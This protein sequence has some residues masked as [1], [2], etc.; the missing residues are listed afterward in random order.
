MAW[1][2]VP[3]LE[4]SRSDFPC[5]SEKA[6]EPCVSSN[7]IL[8]PH[9]LSWAGWRTRPWI[10]RLSGTISRPSMANRGAAS[11]I[12]SLADTHASRSPS[13]VSD[14]ERRIDAI[15][16][17]MYFGSSEKSGRRSVS[18]RTCQ[19]ISDWA[20]PK[21]EPT[22]D[23][24]VMRLRRD[25]LRRQKLAQ[26]TRENVFS[27]WPTVRACSGNRSSGANRTDFYRAWPT[28]DCSDRRGPA[29]AQKGLKNVIE[30]WPTPTAT[31]REND[32]RAIPSRATLERY[33]RGQIRR[34]RKTRAPTLLKAVAQWPTPRT[35]D[36]EGGQVAGTTWNKKGFRS[37]RNKSGQIRGAKL[38]DAVEV[39]WPTPRADQGASRKPGTG[40]RCLPEE[41]NVT[42]KSLLGRQALR[43][44][45]GGRKSSLNT[46][47]SPPLWRTPHSAQEIG[48]KPEELTGKGLGH[49]MYRKD[50]TNH[51][52]DTSL[53]A[54][55]VMGDSAKRLNP[56]F[57]EWLMGFPLAWT[58][59]GVSG[60]QLSHYRRHMRSLLYGLISR[61]GGLL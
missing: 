58:G 28:P 2:F 5:Y 12:S 6:I 33:A 60:M 50:G 42:T 17:R 44:R 25:C 23:H 40:G 51:T 38:R 45:M 48:V 24:L 32:T 56:L 61:D 19:D 11:W 46:R 43:T 16:G 41:A 55:I 29:S 18:S 26:A 15:C 13:L 4:E 20:I 8:S 49:R 39:A 57:V 53:Q 34:I 47:N 37:P 3:G 35:A 1:L 7:G 31:E 59:C 54:R 21:S 36:A 10:S 22:F 27:S 14:V 30:K 9:P 52:Q